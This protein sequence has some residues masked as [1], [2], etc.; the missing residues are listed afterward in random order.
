MP[1]VF[2]SGC[3]MRRPRAVCHRGTTVVKGFRSRRPKTASDRVIT[4]AVWQ[5]VADRQKHSQR[6]EH[7]SG[8]I[9]HT[10]IDGRWDCGRQACIQN[11]FDSEAR[12]ATVR[13]TGSIT[14]ETPVLAERT[15]G[16]PSS[17]A[18]IFACSRC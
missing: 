2:C 4:D 13:P 3:R 15:S 18:R 17:M 7:G 16:S 10:R 12:L 14:A 6:D 11:A 1:T 5:H 8:H 9:A